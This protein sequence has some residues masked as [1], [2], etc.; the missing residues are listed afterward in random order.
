MGN[1]GE[2]EGEMASLPGGVGRSGRGR[3]EGEHPERPAGATGGLAFAR[4]A[5][6]KCFLENM[7]IQSMQRD[8]WPCRRG[9]AGS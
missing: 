4:E 3:D 5:P 8:G 1:F 9:F 7:N 2:Q 6:A